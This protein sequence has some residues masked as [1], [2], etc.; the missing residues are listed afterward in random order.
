ME[1]QAQLGNAQIDE[2]EIA[3]AIVTDSQLVRHR[4]VF[5]MVIRLRKNKPHC[6]AVGLSGGQGR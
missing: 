6:D 1:K 3:G 4:L 5:E 2:L